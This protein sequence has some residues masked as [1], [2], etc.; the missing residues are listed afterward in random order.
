MELEG[1]H[2]K[3]KDWIQTVLSDLHFVKW[4]RFWTDA[5]FNS[6]IPT[7]ITV[8]GWINREQGDYKDFVI[9]DFTLK[10]NMKPSR[11][12]FLGCSSAYYSKKIA[13]ILG[14]K[15]TDCKRV[16]DYFLIRNKVV[17]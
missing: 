11:V 5:E 17:I 3:E 16:E 15:H 1:L 6:N 8:F 13:E 7:L 14:S 2:N 12:Y 4:D 9:L 10:A